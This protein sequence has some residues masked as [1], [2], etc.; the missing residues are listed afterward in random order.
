MMKLN[1]VRQSKCAGFLLLEWILAGVVLGSFAL[2][3]IAFVQRADAYRAAQ[4]VM[5]QHAKQ[6]AHIQRMQTVTNTHRFLF[7]LQEG[8]L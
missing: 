8:P 3:V 6:E 1:S 5:Q 2:F 7:D 4:A